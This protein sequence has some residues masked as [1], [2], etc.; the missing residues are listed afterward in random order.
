MAAAFVF[1]RS[2][3]TLSYPLLMSLFLYTSKVMRLCTRVY[4]YLFTYPTRILEAEKNN[5]N[6]IIVRGVCHRSYNVTRTLQT[7]GLSE[8]IAFPSRH[9]DPRR[10]GADRQIDPR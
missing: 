2:V 6:N 10:N 3:I 5:N 1:F 9:A 7:S 8:R 4:L